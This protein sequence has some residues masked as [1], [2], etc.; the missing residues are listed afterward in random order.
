MAILSVE[1]QKC[2]QLCFEKNKNPSGA[3]KNEDTRKI[4]H[5]C[6]IEMFSENFSFKIYSK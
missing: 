1:R 3:I 6:C 2:V 4:G 5:L